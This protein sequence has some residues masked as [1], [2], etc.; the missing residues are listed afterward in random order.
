MR[1]RESV[2]DNGF[3]PFNLLPQLNSSSH[4]PMRCQQ[5]PLST[6]HAFFTCPMFSPFLEKSLCPNSFCVS[7]LPSIIYHHSF[8]AFSFWY[9]FFNIRATSS[10][11]LSFS[12]K[13]FFTLMRFFFIF[14]FFYFYFCS[15]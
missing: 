2:W 3:A 7:F 5:L 9:L 12:Y 11:S 1:E 14:Y 10:T 4:F 8:I 6:H 15:I 13:S